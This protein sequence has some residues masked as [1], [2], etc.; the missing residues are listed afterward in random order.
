MDLSLSSSMVLRL[1]L[2]PHIAVLLRLHLLLHP[3]S[4]SPTAPAADAASSSSPVPPRP[5]ASAGCTAAGRPS[6][7]AMHVLAAMRQPTSL[8][9]ILGVADPCAPTEGMAACLALA[10]HKAGGTG[11]C[12]PG[13]R[14]VKPA[15]VHASSADTRKLAL[16]A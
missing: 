12:L 8:Q 7:L 3:H 4:S 10:R 2:E 13:P 16:Q 9:T 14:L 1:D 15:A 6:E 11:S 5:S